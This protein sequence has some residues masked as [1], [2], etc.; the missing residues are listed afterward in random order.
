MTIDTVVAQNPPRIFAIS[1]SSLIRWV[2]LPISLFFAFFVL[3][4][5]GNQLLPGDDTV[6]TLNY[7]QSLL[8]TG[9]F[10]AHPNAPPTLGTTSPLTAII[11]SIA[12]SFGMVAW[13][14]P[15]ALSSGAYL[16]LILLFV[17]CSKGLGIDPLTG[18]LIAVLLAVGFPDWIGSVSMEVRLFC[19]FMTLTLCLA[20]NG[21][22][23]AAGIGL[24][25][26]FLVR[27][28]G[29]LLIPLVLF[30]A[31]NQWRSVL[32]SAG[33][34]FVLWAF[35]SW[36]T[37]G[38]ILPNTLSAKRLQPLLGWP[39]FISFLPTAMWFWL[40]WLVLGGIGVF[41]WVRRPDR[42]GL[43]FVVWLIMYLAGYLILNIPAYSWYYLPIL[44]VATICTGVFLA[45]IPRLA[46][47]LVVIAI[48][49]A[50]YS[51]SFDNIIGWLIDPNLLSLNFS[52]S[53][54]NPI[55]DY[56]FIG[57]YIQ[58]NTAPN[59]R[60][61]YIE[62]G[63]LSAL[64]DREV[65]DML[66][67]TNP[68]LLPY[69]AR[70]DWVGAFKAGNPDYILYNSLY[71]F[72]NVINTHP[73]LADRY[74]P[75]H[76]FSSGLKARKGHP[77]ILYARKT[78]NVS[79]LARV[80]LNGELNDLTPGENGA[81][82]A[83]KDPYAVFRSLNVTGVTTLDLLLTVKGG[84]DRTAQLFI[85]EPFSVE[86]SYQF[87][88]VSDSELHSYRFAVNI[89]P[90]WNESVTTLRIDPVWSGGEVQIGDLLLYR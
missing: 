81:W 10:R 63:Y 62:V 73:D 14:V 68:E 78:A 52:H 82:I 74:Y 31:R 35:Y 16:G 44:F 22:G 27:G 7:A 15:F 29:L 49:F 23:I 66:G 70:Q 9:V 51:Q 39:T 38:V 53:G 69:L 71:P 18:N 45:H 65:V 88:L 24:V 47:W 60:I 26:T 36:A 57:P 33:I 61:A 89:L 80:K 90:C 41:F 11:V 17:R 86:C 42:R 76:Q 5:N 1:E 43:V 84:E 79:M 19:F 20:G 72:M 2:V 75:I 40:S 58:A 54:E 59:S 50:V 12:T 37:I 28:E 3:Y 6:I 77:Y 48:T 46:R 30:L 67:L 87:P 64:A 85:G 55:K 13:V 25:A 21:Y 8:E 56:R 4:L 83:G 34:G 32:L